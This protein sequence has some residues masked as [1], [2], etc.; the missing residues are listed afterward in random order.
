MMKRSNQIFGV[1]ILTTCTILS[2][3]TWA[4]CTDTTNELGQRVHTCG[5]IVSIYNSQNQ[6]ISQEEIGYKNGQ[7]YIESYM[8]DT[9]D[10]DG[11]TLLGRVTGR[12]YEDGTSVKNTFTF[13]HTENG[14]ETT[15]TQ[16]FKDSYEKTT[17]FSSQ[18]SNAQ[19]NTTHYESVEY[20]DGKPSYTSHVWD[21]TY[22]ADGTTL[23]GQSKIDTSTNGTVTSRIETYT[24]DGKTK[25][26]YTYGVTY[27][28]DSG[29][30]Q[31]TV[32][33][34]DGRTIKKYAY[35]SLD[36]GGIFKESYLI[37]YSYDDYGGRAYDEEYY[38]EEGNII[39][40]ASFVYLYN[41]DGT[42]IGSSY[43]K[44]DIDGKELS[45]RKD[46]TLVDDDSIENGAYYLYETY[47][48]GFITYRESY[49][50]EDGE[51]TYDTYEYFENGLITQK[52]FYY[53]D[54][55]DAHDVYQYY[56][57]DENGNLIEES[58]E[59][60]GNDAN[61]DW[62]MRSSKGK[63]YE[64]HADGSTKVIDSDGKVHYEG[65]R[66]YTIEEI[67]EVVNSSGANSF[68]FK[69]RYK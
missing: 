38:D 14:I 23:T 17:G 11:V 26:G 18:N 13:S 53:Y 41:K 43:I 3:N 61:G 24:E 69:L 52:D 12:I 48:N 51:N 55:D 47:E 49:I 54:E 58:E 27:V 36:V 42:P 8:Y 2:S 6:Q 10:T 4:A 63:A 9:Y 64:H 67:S 45:S 50:N 1:F 60:W 33:E 22:A 56:T 34:A 46:I 40:N 7:P 16:E 25:T 59:V 31:K 21:Y 65:K 28:D 68:T 57:Y 30:T 5:N 32:Y 66:I 35:E 37:N 20:E 19:G 15:S 62:M 39:A 44:T 29:Y